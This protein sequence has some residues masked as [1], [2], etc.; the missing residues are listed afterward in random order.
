MIL[1]LLTVKFLNT[2]YH[3]PLHFMGIPAF[4]CLIAGIVITG[5][6]S[7]L[8][9]FKSEALMGRPL[10]LLGVLLIITGFHF[11]TLGLLAEMFIRGR[12]EK[13]QQGYIVKSE[14]I[15]GEV[16]DRNGWT[17]NHGKSHQSSQAHPP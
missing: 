14:V 6:L 3:R 8:K 7:Y 13:S 1:D 11:L 15:G 16:H 5:Y 10:L 2:F 4:V 12:R 17:R 9:L